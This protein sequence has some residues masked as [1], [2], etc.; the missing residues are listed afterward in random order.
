MSFFAIA[1]GVAT[2]IENDYGTTAAKAVVFNSWWLELCLF[3]LMTIFLYNI[4]R[5]RLFNI[6]KLPVLFFHLS[7][8]MIIIGAAV[9]RY[10]GE[11]GAMRIREG[12]LNRQFVSETTFFDFKIHNN[13]TEYLGEKEV[14]LSA[15]SNNY[16]S[17]PI[18]LDNTSI[19]IEYLDFINDPVDQIGFDKKN[20]SHILEFIVPASSGGMQS[21]YLDY[22]SVK[23][24]NNIDISFGSSLDADIQ[25]K[26]Q[27]SLDLFVFISKYD[28]SYMQ[29]SDQ[30]KGFLEAGN[31]HVLNQKI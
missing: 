21:E 19:I 1:I 24:I 8:I 23:K 13:K 7:F 9:T 18:D 31:E 4:Y 20:G 16:F 27:D 29:M 2:F 17:F 15:I 14:L 10:T 3:L 6:K 22:N 28:I 25:I 12:D 5:Y 26:Y 11:E 30:K